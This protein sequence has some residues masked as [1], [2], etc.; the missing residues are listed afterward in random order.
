MAARMTAGKGGEYY[1]PYENRKGCESI[2]YFTRDLSAE[3]LEKIYKKVSGV[4]HGKV[5]RDQ[6][7]LCRRPRH[8]RKAPQDPG[9]EWLDLRACRYHR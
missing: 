3:G 1:V 7:L 9:S 8:N 5:H 4:L 2:V 6:H